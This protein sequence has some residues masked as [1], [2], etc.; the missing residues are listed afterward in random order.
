[1]QL[2]FGWAVFQPLSVMLTLTFVFSRP[3][4]VPTE[5]IPY[6][7]FDYSGLLSWRRRPVAARSSSALVS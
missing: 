7:I 2:N 1:L 6:A 3:T 5:G 4:H